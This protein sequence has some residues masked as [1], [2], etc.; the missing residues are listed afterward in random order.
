M[1]YQV[2]S[3]IY[4]V[5]DIKDPISSIIY[6]VLDIKYP[7]STIGCQLSDIKYQILRIIHQICL[8]P[9][10]EGKQKSCSDQKK[11]I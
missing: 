4:P 11:L 1:K 10:G 8:P 9:K 5:S 6:H 7:I 3:V 2:S